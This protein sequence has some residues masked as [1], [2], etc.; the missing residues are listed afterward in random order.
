MSIGSVLLAL[1]GL[2]Q[3]H[4]VGQEPE[5]AVVPVDYV[6]VE[7]VYLPVGA[8]HGLA[9]GDTLVVFATPTGSDVLARLEILSVSRRRSVGMPLPGSAELLRG[10]AVYV[11]L[12]E[13]DRR[14]ASEPEQATEVTARSATSTRVASAPD[15]PRVSGRVGLDMDG[16]E[17]RIS[18][19]G[20]L[21]GET[22]RRFA[23]SV[24]RMAFTASGLPAGFVLRGNLRAAH[25][26]TDFST[27]LP[28]W[29]VRAYELSLARRFER[30]PVDVRLGRFHNPYERFSTYWD[31]ALLRVGGRSFGIGFVGGLEPSRSDE[32]FSSGLPKATAFADLRLGGASWRYATDV[33]WHRLEDDPGYR[34][35]FMG[36]SQAMRVGR[37]ALSSDV[38]VDRPLEASSR[39]LGWGRVRGALDV[40][41]AVTLNATFVRR[42]RGLPGDTAVAEVDHR[43]ERSV[44]LSIRH[45]SGAASLDGGWT[46]WADA[47][48]G[49]YASAALNQRV[50]SFWL[51]AGGRYWTR[52]GAHSI[53]V[54][55]GIGGRI[56]SVDVT[57]SYRLYQTTRE[58]LTSSSHSVDLSSGFSILDDLR[59]TVGGQRQWGANLSGIR[60]H[61]AL[62][63]AF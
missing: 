30:V 24:A 13:V 32:A 60:M 5:R 39:S 14:S 6:G 35:T 43:E 51:R 59:V 63:R 36:W 56:G 54:F 57:A 3:H 16:R 49:Q 8:D 38:R 41:D 12:T 2:W 7:G 1:S 29:S 31:G 19:S 21:S 58:D 50:G 44:G 9:E 33:S 55:P 20:D 45:A 40:S 22:R 47:S 25:R 37:V 53:S 34:R 26:Y 42:A 62:W 61:F 15:G 4:A 48:P 18:W 23:T 28:T 52:E 27:V 11:E 46:R 17:S 10:A